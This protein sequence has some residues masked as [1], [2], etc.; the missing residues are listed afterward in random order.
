M[1]NRG[2]PRST[3]QRAFRAGLFVAGLFLV[4]FPVL[5]DAGRASA[6]AQP[7]SPQP[8]SASPAASRPSP[9]PA[10]AP[11]TSSPPNAPSPAS[12]VPSAGSAPGESPAP[13]AS[14]QPS[15]S[16]SP[17]PTATPTP[18][19]IIVEPPSAGV[20]PG[21][22]QTLRVLR[23]LG[24]L[25]LSVADPSIA[26][27]TVDEAQ[28]TLT[29]VGRA[30]GTT[31]VTI[32]DARGLTRDIAV[33]VALPAGTVAPFTTVRITGNPATSLFVKE[34]ALA[35]ALK[36][37]TI[38]PGARIVA[39]IDAIQLDNPLNID[40]VVTVDVPIILQGDQYFTAQGT[41][42]VRV[43]ND[44]Q[45][46]IRPDALLVSDYPETLRENGTL[47]SSDLTDRAALRFLYYHYNPPGQPDRRIVLKVANASTQPA[48]VQFISGSGGP[49]P[50]E[51]EV[52]HNATERF[53]V[54]LA[55]NE[56]T[57]LT[58][59]GQTTVTLYQQE[60]PAR[61]VVSGILQLHEIEGPPLQLALVAQDAGD[62]VDGPLES[63]VLLAGDHPHARGIYPI[64]EFFFDYAYDCDGPN[65]EM[66]IGQ[67][68]LPNLV[69]GQT[70][71]G[72]YGVLQQITVR[73][74]NNDPRNAR[75][76]ALYANPR[77]GSATGTFI[78]DR[79]LVQAHQMVAFGHYKLRQYT[80]PP[81][82]FVRTEITT[83]PEGGSSYPLRLILAP[84]DGSAAPG[85]SDSPVY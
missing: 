35:A 52:G 13:L 69:Q 38:R 18:L 55:Q 3:T 49:G 41:T 70:L 16:P 27:A 22:S 83:M 67:I 14:G 71:A 57:V 34:Q 65:L 47:F 37:A 68:P 51:M 2:S 7:A 48:R 85:T 84:D 56:G 77:G 36:A 4:A 78:I 82:S 31:V 6:Q 23:S 50:Y 61:S 45:P 58:I 29:I 59:G 20:S 76:V 17:V 60:L 80:I 72:D 25:S 12:A 24:A 43:I 1:Q 75:Q 54:H 19:P 73:M 64:P 62:P 10:A 28:R 26:S 53:L 11:A 63:T 33:R 42:R 40:D 39:P 81:G 9:G 32:A 5:V 8:Q 66:P 30:L 79:E 46:A 74:V 15:P 44:A 21:G